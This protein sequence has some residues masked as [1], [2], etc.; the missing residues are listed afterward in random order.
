MGYA[1]CRDVFNAVSTWLHSNLDITTA[2]HY[3]G[4]VLITGTQLVG[5]Y[6]QLYRMSR[7]SSVFLPVLNDEIS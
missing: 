6:T 3:N 7:F 4:V 5:I 1:A 2:R